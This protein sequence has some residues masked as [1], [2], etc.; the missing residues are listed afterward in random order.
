[1]DAGCELGRG[2]PSSLKKE[3]N[4]RHCRVGEEGTPVLSVITNETERAEMAVSLD[5]ICRQ[6]AQ[7]MLAAAL[8]AEVADYIDGGC[9]DFCVRV[10]QILV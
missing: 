9:Q 3:I 1:M 8:E 6:G 5:E 4:R 10:V 7:Q 2:V